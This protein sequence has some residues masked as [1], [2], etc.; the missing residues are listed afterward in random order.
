MEIQIFNTWTHNPETDSSFK[1]PKTIG[2]FNFKIYLLDNLF[3]DFH[4]KK[5]SNTRRKEIQ[6]TCW[7]QTMKGIRIPKE[8]SE[9]VYENQ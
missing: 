9:T 6:N 7:K 1:S 3:L 5:K 2:K 4:L 8:D